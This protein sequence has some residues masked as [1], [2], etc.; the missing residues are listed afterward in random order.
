M[1]EPELLR[2]LTDDGVLVLTLNRPAT[3]NALSN[4]LARGIIEAAIESK[5]NDAIWVIVITGAGRGFC[6]GADL[7]GG[8]PARGSGGPRPRAA[9]TDKL[10]TSG[11]IVKALA[12]A[13]V[14]IVG[15]INGAAAGAGFGLALC[16]DVR[17]ASDQ[18]RMGSIFIKR[19]LGTD[20]GVSWWLPRLVG[21]AK[22]FELLYSGDIL[23]AQ[24]LLGLG[25]VNRVVPHESLMAETMAYARTIAAGP[26]FAYT[27]T[28]RNVMRAIDTGLDAQVESEWRN[29]VELLG[30]A[31]AAEGFR[32]FAERRAPTFTGR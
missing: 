32:A 30:T 1:T 29:Q 4:D 28:R 19:G 8:G 22:A 14:P 10:G 26:P 15:A 3:M 18:A 21:A 20:Y 13:D 5:T 12:N 9:A 23:D 25:L 27:Y 17:I 6:A 24:A 31:D 2:E 16:C 7:S 11:A